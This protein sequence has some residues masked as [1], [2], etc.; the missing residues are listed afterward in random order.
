[1]SLAWLLTMK[2][3]NAEPEFIYFVL[4][5][6]FANGNPGN[7]ILVVG[8]SEG[9]NDGWLGASIY[10][11]R[12]GDDRIYAPPPIDLAAERAH[13][14]F[15]RQQILAGKINAAHDISDGGLAVGGSGDAGPQRS[16]AVLV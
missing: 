11:Q 5:D 3:A 13:G 12:F 9:K 2:M 6:R 1:M 8:Q 15:V 7:D 4:V 14:S 10:Q 16:V